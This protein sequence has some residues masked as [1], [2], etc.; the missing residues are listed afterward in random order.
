[1]YLIYNHAHE[2]QEYW[3]YR[4]IK[5]I[6]NHAN[7]EY[8]FTN[9]YN[10]AN[11]VVLFDISKDISFIEN[12]IDTN[13]IYLY[14]IFENIDYHKRY[15]RNTQLIKKLMNTKNLRFYIF[16]SNDYIDNYP[17]SF[18]FTPDYYFKNLS[19]KPQDNFET[20]YENG[21]CHK[22]H[23]KWRHRQ[24]L[25][26]LYKS[27]D[28]SN[29]I[30]FE[31]SSY[32]ALIAVYSKYLFNIACENSRNHNGSYITEKIWNAAKACCIPIYWGGNISKYTILNTK[33]IIMVDDINN[34]PDIS[35]LDKNYLYDMYQLPL[36]NENH[37]EI[38]EELY[39][40]IR[41]IFL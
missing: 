2:S 31:L 35:K 11:V 27:N 37:K 38:T 34:P 39:D 10:S 3:T 28:L 18:H 29:I 22:Y 25:I 19:I 16:G 41:K 12:N 6:L 40:K 7:I 32:E 36:F 8:E 9:N 23:M 5:E 26:E 4:K 20:R 24:K 1:M 17:N 15:R 13:K 14:L 21:I 30:K 33:R